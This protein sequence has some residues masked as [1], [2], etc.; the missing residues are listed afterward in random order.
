MRKIFLLSALVLILCYANAQS[1]KL[2][3]HPRV[4]VTAS[5]IPDLRKAITHK[6][7]K[8][9]WESYEQQKSRSTRGVSAD[10]QPDESIRECIEALAFA[11]LLDTAHEKLAGLKAIELTKTYLPSITKVDGYHSNAHAYWS[12]LT[13]ALVYDWCY[14]LLDVSS[15]YSLRAAMKKV[16]CLAEYCLFKNTPKQYLSGHYGEYAPT[17][18]LA[19]GL[20]I[21]DE[22]PTVFEFAYKEQVQHFAPSRNPW[23]A[24]GTNHQGS[25][26]IHVR[27]G[28]ELLQAYLLQN[29]GLSP[30]DKNIGLTAFREMYA[31]VPQAG[32]MDGM[33]EGDCHNNITMGDDYMEFL[34][35]AARI[36]GNGYL[37]AYAKMNLKKLI[38][39]STRALLFYNPFLQ[40][41]SL[42][43]LCLTRF[44]S[45]PSGIMIARTGWDLQKK[46]KQSNAMIVLM[47]M[48]EYN[49]KNHVH[50]DVGHF[51][52]YYKGHLALDAGIYQG[53]DDANGW[54]KENYVNYYART[55]AHNS[56]LVLDPHEPTPYEG[57]NKKAVSRD[58]GQFSF[59]NRAWDSLQEMMSA[60]KPATILASSI[61]PGVTPNYSYLMGDM[62]NA[63]NV[64]KNVAAYPAKVDTVR[65]SFVFLNLKNA[66]VPGALIVLDRIVSTNIYFQKKWLLHTQQEPQINNSVITSSNTNDG[67]NGKLV[68]QILLPAKDN[69]MVEKVGG[70]GKEFFVDGKNWGS[71]VQEDAGQWRIE[72]SPR[73]SAKGD[74]FLN[75]LQAMDAKPLVN[76]LPVQTMY[77]ANNKQ[78][79]VLIQD[80][81]VIQNIY[82][83]ESKEPVLFSKIGKAL[84]SYDLLVTN[85]AYGEWQLGNNGSTSNFIVTPQN[86]TLSTII[87]GG[88]I[89]LKKVK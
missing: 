33:P 26:Y 59:K 50:L 15:K 14:P 57:S 44:F 28:N 64:P 1:I 43:N 84:D 37:Q 6:D 18:F 53:S 86:G 47:N 69:L 79:A 54:G 78:I 88:S 34:P 73:Q 76:A 49:A 4:F 89:T 48:R 12:V 72:V 17:V 66:K 85:L 65:R 38:G 16:S 87:K 2:L 67:R 7:L 24:A 23:Y 75:V 21:Y 29:V 40:A 25:Q 31:N 13:A 58:G 27:Y 22:D 60:P 35:L 36:S 3:P 77:S 62:T 41:S 10:G 51:G 19:M 70:K 74:N 32:D 20:A 80:R 8:E 52:I 42:D 63:Y 83:A 30:Y 9:I 56:I 5:K 71:V 82:L 11:Y 68:S 81:I 46:D 45:S 55:V 61:A 39:F